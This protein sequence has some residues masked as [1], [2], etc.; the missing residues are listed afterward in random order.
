MYVFRTMFIMWA[1]SFN[2]TIGFYQ[3]LSYIFISL[4]SC[5]IHDLIIVYNCISK[6]MR[7]NY[8]RGFHN[9]NRTELNVISW[10]CEYFSRPIKIDSLKKTNW[11]SAIEIFVRYYGTSSI[12]YGLFFLYN[13]IFMLL[14]CDL[15]IHWVVKF[16]FF[17]LLFRIPFKHFIEGSYWAITNKKFQSFGNFHIQK[18]SLQKYKCISWNTSFTYIASREDNIAKSHKVR[19]CWEPIWN[20]VGTPWKQQKSKKIV[21]LWLSLIFW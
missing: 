15:I 21:S 8:T 19:C 20:F 14:F 16:Y 5:F 2:N 12:L 6:K 1:F 7:D 10:S 9:K 4:H 17:S 13:I 3:T 11:A 18:Y